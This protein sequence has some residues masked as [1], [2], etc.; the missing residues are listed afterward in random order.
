VLVD[1]VLRLAGHSTTALTLEQYLIA[2]YPEH[3]L[4]SK[5]EFP[6]PHIRPAALMDL[7]HPL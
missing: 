1:T 2:L 4:T 6:I 7:P 5:P 3:D